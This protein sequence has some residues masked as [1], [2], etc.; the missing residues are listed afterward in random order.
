[1]L[2]ISFLSIFG[3]HQTYLNLGINLDQEQDRAPALG[4]ATKDGRADIPEWSDSRL[5]ITEAVTLPTQFGHRRP[6]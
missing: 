5:G 6:N 1:M 3:Q 4:Q 2:P